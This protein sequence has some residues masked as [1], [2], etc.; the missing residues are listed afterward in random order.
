MLMLL[1]SVPAVVRTQLLLLGLLF[2]SAAAG[3]AR[4]GDAWGTNI[5]FMSEKAPGEAA[6]LARAF[7]LARMDFGWA[8]I[9]KEKG[10]YD[11]SSYDGLLAVMKAHGIRP[12]WILDYGNPL[13]PYVPPPS[14]PNTQNCTTLESCNATW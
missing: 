10:K 13:Y 7:K 2:S 9:E 12:Y 5:H 8:A 6:M 11:F 4:V 3:A 14:P 1:T